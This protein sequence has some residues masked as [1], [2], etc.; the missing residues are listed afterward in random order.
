MREQAM[1]ADWS[2]ELDF[3]VASCTTVGWSRGG[4]DCVENEL[5]VVAEDVM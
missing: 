4:W 1:I 3:S 2:G 5:M